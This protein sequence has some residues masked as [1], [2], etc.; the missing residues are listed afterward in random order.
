MGLKL[1]LEW[2]EKQTEIYQG[3]E[4]SIDFGD[5]ASVLD[6]L[7]VPIENSINNGGFDVGDHWVDVIQPHFRHSIAL[8]TYDYQIAFDYRDIW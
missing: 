7:G 6:A 2:Y 5:D 1:R 8:K 3:E 4:Y